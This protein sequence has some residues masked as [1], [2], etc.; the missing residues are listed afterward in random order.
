MKAYFAIGRI[1]HGPGG[2]VHAWLIPDRTRAK[3]EVEACCGCDVEIIDILSVRKC[4]A[5][6]EDKESMLLLTHFFIFLAQQ[7][8]DGKFDVGMALEELVEEAFKSGV[9][10]ASCLAASSL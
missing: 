9:R 8:G 3:E 7:P 5:G 6:Q 4:F 10:A 2:P 1:K